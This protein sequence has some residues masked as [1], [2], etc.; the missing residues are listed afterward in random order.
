MKYILLT[1]SLITANVFAHDGLGNQMTNQSNSK[2]NG[3]MVVSKK[4]SLNNTY[5]ITTTTESTGTVIKEYTDLNGK[6]FAITWSGQVIPNLEELLGSYFSEYK[7]PKNFVSHSGHSN[8][9]V[10]N[11]DMVVQS[12]GHLR[13]FFGTAYLKSAIPSGVDINEIQ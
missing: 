6:I 7:N 11:G 9:M 1:L 4:A 10:S 3:L 13:A 5:N 8:L 12:R 2:L